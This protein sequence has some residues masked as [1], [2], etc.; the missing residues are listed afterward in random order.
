MQNRNWQN[1][2]T[3][4]EALYYSNNLNP[5]RYSLVKLRNER[6]WNYRVYWW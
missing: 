4:E 5:R 1:F 3:L 6:I 2:V